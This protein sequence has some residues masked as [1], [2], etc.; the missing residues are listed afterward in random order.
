MTPNELVLV[1][2]GAAVAFGIAVA[3]LLWRRVA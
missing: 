2:A 3:A 1:F